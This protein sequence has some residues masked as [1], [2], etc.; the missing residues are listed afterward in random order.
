MA[1]TANP[2]AAFKPPLSIT[3]NPD[4]VALAYYLTVFSSSGPF[5]YLSHHVPALVCDKDILEALHATAFA[6]MALAH[7]STELMQTARAHY[8][9]ALTQ[10]N[11]D[12]SDPQT[13]ILD[14]TLARVLLLSGFEALAF[15]GRQS[16]HDW[17]LHVQGLIHL[18]R[19]RGEAQL[20]SDIGRRLL[21]LATINILTGCIVQDL[22]V[23]SG[24]LDLQ[25]RTSRFDQEHEFPD[26]RF[27]K[28][29]MDY[30]TMNANKQI[31]SIESIVEE[32]LRLDKEAAWLLDKFHEH[33][34]YMLLSIDASSEKVFANK[35]NFFSPGAIMH[36]YE[37]QHAARF[38]N[39]LRLLRVVANE[40]VFC[41]LKSGLHSAT[42]DKPQWNIH[43]SDSNRMIAQAA[44][45]ASHIIDD[46]L[47]SIPYSLNSL[48]SQS[49]KAARSL[50]WPL[51]CAASCDVCPESKRIFITNCLREI[52]G[53]HTLTQA[54]HAATMLEERRQS[55]DW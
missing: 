19:L 10:T 31:L 49:G 53:R 4:D 27:L 55:E 46:M 13:A 22:P 34:P 47:S 33:T 41:A 17:L 16:P 3:I 54:D 40:W 45:Q 23:P 30:V 36:Q 50:I 39:T 8:L 18:L 48:Q 44:T 2:E 7:Q 5:S 11:R 42:E 9:Q 51:T 32:A 15:H 14:K 35:A 28:A 12:L 24:L 37:S 21:H 26:G 38:S 52:A 20:E 6:S 43:C 25:Q 29:V 1:L